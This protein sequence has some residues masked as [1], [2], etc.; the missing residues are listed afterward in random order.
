MEEQETKKTIGEGLP[1]GTSPQPYEYEEADDRLPRTVSQAPVGSGA[2]VAAAAAAPHVAI[3]SNGAPIDGPV[4]VN[5][6]VFGRPARKVEPRDF[7]DPDLPVGQTIRIYYRKLNGIEMAAALER[8]DVLAEEF[9]RVDSETGEPI[10]I[11]TPDPTSPPIVVTKRLL[12]N[13]CMLEQMQQGVDVSLRYEVMEMIG[14][15]LN[16]YV[17][18]QEMLKAASAYLPVKDNELGKSTPTL[19]SGVSG[20]G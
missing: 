8:A 14:I 16:Y 1:V 12:T 3:G 7:T 17:A 20:Q 11:P 19:A 2:P 13:L 18:F 9:C 10:P 5:P 6:W 15:A 4:K